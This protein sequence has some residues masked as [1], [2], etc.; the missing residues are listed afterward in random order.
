MVDQLLGR[1]V[2]ELVRIGGSDLVAVQRNLEVDGVVHRR[3][4]LEVR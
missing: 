2:V 1:G 3:G 4:I